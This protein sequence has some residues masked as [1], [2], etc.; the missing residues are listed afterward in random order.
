MP[1]RAGQHRHG[2]GAD[3]VG[4]VAVGGDAV[5]ADDDQVDPPRAIRAPALRVGDHA[6]GD[7]ARLELPGGEPR[8]LQE[9]PGLVAQH[10]GHL[11]RVRSR[12]G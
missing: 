10:L 9:R 7:A 8:A 11:A 1:W 12:A 5:G 6:V 2:V 3:L 4:D